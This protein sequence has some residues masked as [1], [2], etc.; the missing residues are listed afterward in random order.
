MSDHVVYNPN[1]TAD[2]LLAVMFQC[3]L[4]TL[5]R[6]AIHPNALDTRILDALK[7][8]V[9]YHRAHKTEMADQLQWMVDCVRV[10]MNHT[11]CEHK[12]EKVTK[13]FQDKYDAL[14]RSHD[15]LEYNTFWKR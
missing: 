2:Q 6:I 8:H 11:W 15:Y 7:V 1:A 3:S 9:A 13:E 10:R 5:C 14:K 12:L 4:D